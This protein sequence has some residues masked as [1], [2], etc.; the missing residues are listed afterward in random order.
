MRK[1]R[2]LKPKV[3][4]HVTATANRKE[5]IFDI[6]DN[7]EIKELYLDVL[8]EARKKFNFTLKIIPL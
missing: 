7:N 8:K 6:F 5:Y 1:A 2:V 3:Y 4:Y